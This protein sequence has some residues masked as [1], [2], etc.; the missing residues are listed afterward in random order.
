M[1][2]IHLSKK[3]II[4]L[5]IIFIAA[6]ALAG[7]Y[8]WQRLER[9]TVPRQLAKEERQ[10]Y[11]Q[12]LLA[13]EQRIKELQKQGSQNKPELFDAFMQAGAQQYGLGRLA[14]AERSYRSAE[15]IMPDNPAGWVALH[16]VLVERK[17][18]EEA[19]K[20]IVK[21][22]EIAPRVPDLWRRLITFKKLYGNLSAERMNSL[23]LEAL[24]KTG[25]HA[26]IL[27]LYARFE[28]EQGNL[29]VAMD[30][31]REALKQ[32]PQNPAFREEY[33][34]LQNLLNRK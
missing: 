16:E 11:E 13:A 30:L 23:Y 24:N 22:T 9:V 12:R 15:E 31:W 33:E 19:G 7:V 21:A 4:T 8:L 27:V 3:V 6:S 29:K 17:K 5:L 34:R 2:K 20:A 18:Y 25:G 26:E 10:R 28:E 32:Q 14:D 1:T